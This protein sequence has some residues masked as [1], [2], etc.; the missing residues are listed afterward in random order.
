MANNGTYYDSQSGQHV[1]IHDENKI[2]CYL[3]GNNKDD[4]KSPKDI[5]QTARS[6]GLSG[7]LLPPI[8]PQK[9]DVIDTSAGDIWFLHLS[10]T[11]QDR[12]SC[13]EV[14]ES[15]KSIECVNLCF[16]FSI[17]DK[18]VDKISTMIQKTM[19]DYG[20]RTSIGIFD[21]KCFNEDPIL[22]ASQI[23]NI[24]DTTLIQQ[25]IVSPDDN[26]VDPDDLR[27]LCE[28]LSYLDVPGPTVKSRLVVKTM[29]EEQVEECLQM[30]I[31]KFLLPDDGGDSL[32]M[33]KNT[34]DSAGKEFHLKKSAPTANW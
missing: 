6:I 26:S 1:P 17:E 5:V 27:S 11:F 13:D 18:S 22:V 9:R 24:I 33:I 21:E 23:A 20:S 15:N 2:H 25:V 31:S 28:E 10:S 29:N 34:V 16:E 12:L 32:D 4:T 14:I 7:C 8:V 3:I 30:G 19:T